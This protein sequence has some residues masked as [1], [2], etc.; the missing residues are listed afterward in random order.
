MSEHKRHVSWHSPNLD[1]TMAMNIWGSDSAPFAC[2]VFPSSEGRFYDF[3]DRGMV[4]SLWPFVEGGKLQLF[5]VDSVDSES[6]FGPHWKPAEERAGRH[7]QYDKYVA[8]EVVPYVE[9]CGPGRVLGTTGVSWGG[10][11]AVNSL[12]KHPHLFSYAVGMSSVLSLTE[13][14]GTDFVNDSIYFNDPSRYLP[15]LTDEA[16]LARLRRTF[17][18]L[19]IGGGRWEEEA[20][21]DSY[22]IHS[23]LRSKGVD[24]WLDEWGKDMDHDW[25]TWLRM[26]PYFFGKVVDG[27]WMAARG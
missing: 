21:R 11:H 22:F 13:V 8:E 2:V 9:K 25:P 10:Y 3:E 18:I 6:F 23:V 20:R 7:V 16:V 27:G 12:L 4:S 26:A 14:L 17:P 1:R 19:A 5:C 24:S 15:N